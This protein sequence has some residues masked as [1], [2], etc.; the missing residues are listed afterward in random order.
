MAKFSQNFA[1]TIVVVFQ[2][3]QKSLPV[4]SQHRWV[5]WVQLQEKY[6]FTLYSRAV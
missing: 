4:F 3:P 1:L 5:V 6:K 2:M